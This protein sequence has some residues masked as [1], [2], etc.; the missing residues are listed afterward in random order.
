MARPLWNRIL[1]LGISA[2]LAWLGLKY[3]LPL[4]LPFLLGA[5]L[6][7]AAEPGVAVLNN[8][9]HLPRPAASVVGIT[10]ALLLLLGSLFF[11]SSLVFRRLGSLGTLLPQL[12]DTAADGLHSLEL[13]LHTLAGQAPER[14]RE[15]LNDGV[16]RLF[17]SGGDL[18]TQ[19]VGRLPNVLTGVISTLSSS[20]LGVG[21][22]ILSAFMISM[23]LPQLR[24][25]LKT[26]TLSARF[27]QYR[28]VLSRIKTSLLGWLKAQLSLSGI[29]FLILAAGF[30]LLGISNGPVWAFFTA[31]VDAVPILGTGTILLPWALVCFVQGN[32][33]RATGLLILYAATFLARTA[34]EPRLVGK[35]IGLDPLI[36]LISLYIGFQ[37]WGI[38]GLLLAPMAAVVIKELSASPPSP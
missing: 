26:S 17:R 27:S 15:P 4:L 5:L 31:L 21:T 8:R 2:L 10:A 23:R 14:L 20:A 25:R 38:P 3:M 19:L 9:F 37:L 29:S 30:L 1:I 6:A 28:P 33:L 7:L 18:T 36:T 12:T 35:Q 24:Q 11:L 34:L 32:T 22:S 16:T 13:Q